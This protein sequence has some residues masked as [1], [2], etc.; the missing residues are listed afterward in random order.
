MSVV[1][2]RHVTLETVQIEQRLG[3]DDQGKPTYDT[4]V[5]IDVRIIR[6]DRVVMRPDGTTMQ[7]E[8]TVWV[9]ADAAVLPNEHDRLTYNN[10]TFFVLQVK[11]V[12]DRASQLVHRRLRTTPRVGQ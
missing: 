2:N 10:E 4:P 11:D 9:P 1:L 6:Q 12:K 8:L 3:L 7:L 5:D